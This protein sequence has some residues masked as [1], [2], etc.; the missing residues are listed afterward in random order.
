[1]GPL[2]KIRS[3]STQFWPPAPTI[4]ER[5]I[6]SGL[7]RGKVFVVTGGSAGI[8]YELCKI[9]FQGG[10]TIY[11]ATRSK[12]GTLPQFHDRTVLI[13]SPTQERAE[14]AIQS[15]ENSYPERV[16]TGQL[17]FLHLDLS[18]LVSVREAASQFAQQETKLHVLWNN[19]GIGANAVKYGERTAQGSEILMGIHCVGALLFTQLLVPQLKAAADDSA[20]SRVV[21]LST[22][23]VDTS[24]PNNGVD[25]AAVDSGIEGRIA[26]YAASKAGVWMLSREFARRHGPDGILSVTL[27]PGSLDAGSFNGTPRI[28]LLLMKLTILHKPVFGAYTMLYAGLSPDIKKENNGIFVYPWGRLVPDHAVVRQDI[29]HAMGREEEGGLGLGKK[30]WQWCETRWALDSES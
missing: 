24:A 5:D 30:L 23:L 17:K 29:L 3:I 4:T 8:G 16:E 22:I 14:A 7:H 26:N 13:R 20:P 19:A 21:W 18:D 27:N 15:I 6:T 10:A 25:F 2:A 9:L 1:M 11:M 28:P 12:V